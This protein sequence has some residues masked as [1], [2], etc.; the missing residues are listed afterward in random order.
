MFIHGGFPTNKFCNVIWLRGTLALDRG[1][2][3]MWCTIHVFFMLCVMSVVIVMV[4]SVNIEVHDMV[5]AI[6]MTKNN[7]DDVT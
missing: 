7:H 4:I 3:G 2:V 6:Y 1:A 5:V